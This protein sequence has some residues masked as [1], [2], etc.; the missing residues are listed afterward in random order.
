MDLSKDCL[1]NLCSMAIAG[2]AFALGVSGLTVATGAVE[3]LT[4]SGNLALDLRAEQKNALDAA[5]KKV[6]KAIEKDY[7]TWLDSEVG[8]DWQTQADVEAALAGLADAIQRAR[9]TVQDMIDVGHRALPDKKDPKKPHLVGILLARLP[10]DSL[11][12]TNE[13]AGQVF[14][15]LIASVHGIARQDDTLKPL[16]DTLSQEKVFDE[17]G[18]VHDTLAEHGELLHQILAEQKAARGVS[19]DPENLRPL[20]EAVE[21]ELPAADFE[22]AIREAVAELTARA[23]DP[24]PLLND[25]EEIRA[26]IQLARQKLTQADADGAIEHLRRARAEQADLREARA[27]GEAR[28]AREE[29]EIL[30]T[31]F[32]YDEA[33]AAYRQAAELDPDDAGSR[34]EIGDIAM[35]R[36]N[37]GKALE[38]YQHGKQAAERTGN[39]RDL[40]VSYTKIGDVETARGDLDAARKAY[41]D[42]LEIAERLA[43]ADPANTQWQRDLSV[44]YDRIGDVETA[45]GDL[46]AARKAYQAGLEIAERLA[47]ADPAN[48]QWQRDLSVSYNKIGDVETARGD[49]DAARRAYQDGLEIAER[50]TA[51]DPANTQWQRDLSVSYNKI[52]DVE[53]AR[54]DLDAALKAYQADLKIAERLAAADPANTLWQRDLSVSYNRIGDVETARGDLDA[55]LRAYQDSQKI[56]ERL[57]AAD[58]ANTEWQWDLFASFWRMANMEIEPARNLRQGLAILENLHTDGRLQPVRVEWIER[59][60]QRLETLE[61]GTGAE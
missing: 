2:G 7:A 3:L 59:T 55:A 17:F 16:F 11:Y 46:D 18:K 9:P 14:S 53:T 54:G 12:R 28:L 57:A 27:R 4:S 50:L 31:V 61:D 60:R 1:K 37:L 40:S 10:E 25:P 56:F 22:G 33:L 39:E 45:R 49:L 21:R 41:Q 13:T 58:P 47:A 26:A 24:V 36:G 23:N 15:T 6:T 8:A 38:A 35:H 48:T 20:F 5:A 42:G 51:A 30:K 52:G 19:I 43:A 29:A 44:S 32:R 34:F